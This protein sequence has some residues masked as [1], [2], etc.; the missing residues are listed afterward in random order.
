[1]GKTSILATTA[2]LAAAATPALGCP[3]VFLGR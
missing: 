3:G 2:L 1:M